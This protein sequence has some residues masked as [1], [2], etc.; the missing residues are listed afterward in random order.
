MSFNFK[1]IFIASVI[2][3]DNLVCC[4][5]RHQMTELTIVYSALKLTDKFYWEIK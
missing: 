5:K 4:L 3:I 2:F 1:Q